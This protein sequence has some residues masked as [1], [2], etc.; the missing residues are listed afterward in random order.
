MRLFSPANPKSSSRAAFT[1]ME[2]ALAATVL[3]LTLVGMINVVEA[4]TQMLDVARKQTIASQILHGEIDQLRTQSWPVISGYPPLEGSLPSSVQVSFPSSIQVGYT[5]P[6]QTLTTPG[7]GYPVGSSSSSSLTTAN[8]PSFALFA[9]NNPQIAGRFSV[10][11]TVYIINSHSGVPTLLQ[12]EFTV[13]WAG[14]TN[15]SY[16]RKATTLVAPNGLN[17]AY[18]IP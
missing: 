10:S 14:V 7:C 15:H 3:A 16:S 2:V 12:V 9:A 11:R 5:G 8:D 13:T 18:Q 17:L 1:I 4:G 6:A